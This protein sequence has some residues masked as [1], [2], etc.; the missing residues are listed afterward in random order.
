MNISLVAN[1][2][3]FFLKKKKTD[4]RPVFRFSAKCKNGR[5]SVIPTISVLS[6]WI[7]FLVTRMVP[8]IFVKGSHKKKL[9]KSGQADRLGRGG[10]GGGGSPPSSLAASIL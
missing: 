2:G 3:S 9:I 5:F 7:I 1:F 8:T 10:G 6:K 4:F